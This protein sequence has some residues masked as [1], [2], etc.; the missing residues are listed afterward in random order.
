MVPRREQRPRA[1]LVQHGGVRQS[2]QSGGASGQ[3]STALRL[4]K[5]SL[6]PVLLY[7]RHI[8]AASTVQPRPLLESHPQLK[9]EFIVTN[10]IVD[11][12][13]EN[14][15][16]SLRMGPFPD[17]RLV[18]RKILDLRRI[19]CASPGYIARRGRPTRPSDLLDHSCLTLSRNPGSA[20][21]SFYAKCERTVAH[22]KG[23]VS[24]DSAEMLLRL[25]ICA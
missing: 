20:A 21:W 1:A 10:R 5:F 25:A 17:S 22:V 19:V 7:R 14:I 9:F 11:L 12:I 15:D 3:G 16:I 4:Q 6:T 8:C 24:A 23:P 2:S 13:D 18:R